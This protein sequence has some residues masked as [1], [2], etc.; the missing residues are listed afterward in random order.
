[1]ATNEVATGGYWVR[2]AP[3]Y[4]TVFR[5]LFGVIWLVDGALKFL[6]GFVDQFPGMVSDAAAGQPAWMSWWFDFWVNQANTNA[7]FWVY[8]TGVLELALGIALVFG[9][10]RKVAYA[11]GIA[12]SLLI[13]TVPEGFGGTYSA[14]TTDPGVGVVYAILF[15]ALIVINATYGPSRWSVDALIE[16]RFPKWAALAELRREAPAET[17]GRPEVRRPDARA[18]A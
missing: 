5:I 15:L 10:L 8:S 12:L 3:R 11:G 14:G 6:A 16:R 18:G 9:L 1:M 4:K 17:G 2:N 7:A 13:W